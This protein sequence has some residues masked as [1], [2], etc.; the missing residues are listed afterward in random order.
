MN[1]E[2]LIYDWANQIWLVDASLTNKYDY[3]NNVYAAF[4]TYSNVLYEFNFQLG[5]RAEYMDR[6][7]QQKTFGSDYRYDKLD[8]FPT[9]SVSRKIDDHQLQFSYSRRINRPNEVFLNPFP[10]YTDTYLTSA[11]NPR[12]LPEYTNSFELNYQNT[13]SGVFLS[14]QTYLRASTGSINQQ[15][16]ID[17]TG[18]MIAIFDNFAKTTTAGAEL[19]ASYSPF[20]WLR[21]D[22]NVNLYDNS[23][24]GTLLDEVVKSHSFEWTSRLTSTFTITPDTRLQVTGIYEGKQFFPQGEVEP[25]FNLSVS[26][27]QNFFQKALSLTL[28]GQNLLH[29]SNFDIAAKGPNFRNSFL[30]KSEVPVINLILTYNFNNF[31]KSERPTERV[32]V[33]VGM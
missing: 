10:Y 27:K 7:L 3:R 2:N 30:V 31:K 12:L 17:T 9:F 32:D 28:Q 25:T 16:S 26:A 19:S 33:N 29:T 11:G 14:A 21:L 23:M 8:F 24:N 13:F 4:A 6:L 5:L 15:F 22:P 1:I 20:A 18:R